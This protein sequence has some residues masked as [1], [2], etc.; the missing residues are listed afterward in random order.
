MSAGNSK[1]VV[2]VAL[3]ANLGIA[4]AKF[5]GAFFSHSASLLAE[6]IHSLVD[7]TNQLF[8]LVGS[9]KSSKPASQSHPLGYGR[10]SFFWSF[11][12][13][14][15]LFFMGGLFA[16]YEGISKLH[17]ESE[18]HSPIVGVAI[19]L[20]SAI[21]EGFS[22]FACVNEI[23]KQNPFKSLWQWVKKTTSSELLVIFLE[24]IGAMIGLSVALISLS[25][26]WIT[27]DSTWDAM[28]SILVGGVLVMV[29]TLLAVEIK[30]LIIGE[31]PNTDFHA[32]I[33]QK[34]KEQMGGKVFKVIALQTGASEVML[35]C[36]FHP[37]DIK[38]TKALVDA[39]N[40]IEKEVKASF[41]EV[42]W[43]FFEPD[44]E[45]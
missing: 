7:C 9:A 42:R 1:K 25:L 22:L 18:M 29:A 31:A 23:Q 19:L 5:A 6:A 15:F 3:S 10:E 12:V 8:L 11:I 38:D 30:S 16:I 4:L 35:S 20:V 37:G 39:I 24:D 40:K 2:L 44:F 14:I 34:I 26:A 36:K 27:G 41:P 17:V 33:E 32:F 28:G 13:A 21:L 43:Q 45:D